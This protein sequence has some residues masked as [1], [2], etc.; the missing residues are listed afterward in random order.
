VNRRNGER[1][2]GGTDQKNFKEGKKRGGESNWQKKWER[3]NL[4]I[5]VLCGAEGTPCLLIGLPPPSKR[6]GEKRTWRET[7]EL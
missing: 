2:R 1:G 3:N 7:K 6:E 4:R 5:T